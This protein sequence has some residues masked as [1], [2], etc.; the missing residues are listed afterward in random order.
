MKVR[1]YASPRPMV[2]SVTAM[3]R[4]EYA[5]GRARPSKKASTPRQT[6]YRAAAHAPAWRAAQAA[7]PG[8]ARATSRRRDG[9]AGAAD[10]RRVDVAV[11]ARRVSRRPA[12]MTS[13]TTYAT[14][15]TFFRK[16]EPEA[17][18]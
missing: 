7:L 18:S 14:P 13:R 17:G 16:S 8:V 11:L 10:A 9:G 5:S 2:R 12:K 3:L 6:A 4:A 15:A 1:R